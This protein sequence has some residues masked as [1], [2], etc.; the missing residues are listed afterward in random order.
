MGHL[1]TQSLSWIFLL[2][3][4]MAN[5]PSNAVTWLSKMILLF[6]CLNS[7]LSRISYADRMTLL[8]IVAVH[9]G[10]GCLQEKRKK[11]DITVL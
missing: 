10:M 1:C 9:S 7:F 3:T 11:K 6:G 4:V 5:F 8:V 2:T